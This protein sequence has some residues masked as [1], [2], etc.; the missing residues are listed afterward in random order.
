MKLVRV[1][2]QDVT[3]PEVCAC[4][5]AK[6]TGTLEVRK[7]DLAALAKAGLMAVAGRPMAGL[8]TIRTGSSSVRAWPPA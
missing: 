6:S 3:Y 8:M 2:G 1:P 5:V 4:C 7:E